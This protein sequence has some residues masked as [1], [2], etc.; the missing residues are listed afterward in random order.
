MDMKD[1]IRKSIMERLAANFNGEEWAKSVIIEQIVDVVMNCLNAPVQDVVAAAQTARGPYSLSLMSLGK[2]ANPESVAG[3]WE[4]VA[5]RGDEQV[6]IVFSTKVSKVLYVFFM[7]HAGEELSFW[8]M[9]KCHDELKRIALA[10]YTDTEMSHTHKT[11]QWAEDVALR[12]SSRFELKEKKG[13]NKVRSEAFSKAKK[14]VQRALIEEAGDYVIQGTTGDKN[15][16]LRLSKDLVKVPNAF[17][18]VVIDW[19][20]GFAA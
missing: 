18:E 15:R 16:V 20:G 17:R 11:L 13:S 14:A 6:P 3:Y 1:F 7:L 12:L 5:V 4:V 8:N 10:L 2:K 9:E 19:K